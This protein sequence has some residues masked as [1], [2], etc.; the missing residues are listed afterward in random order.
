MLTRFD[1]NTVLVRVLPSANN[2]NKFEADFN[3]QAQRN[4]VFLGNRNKQVCQMY[5]SS[6]TQYV[7]IEKF[8]P[9]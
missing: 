9:V 2:A 6:S 7:N 1:Y 4:T 5:L 8:C 3:G